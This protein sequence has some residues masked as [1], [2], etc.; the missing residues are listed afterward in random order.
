MDEDEIWC[1]TVGAAWP[2][3]KWMRRSLA[4]NVACWRRSY[5]GGIHNDSTIREPCSC[6]HCK[7]TLEAGQSE[8]F[9]AAYAAGFWPKTARTYQLVCFKRYLL[10]VY[11]LKL[12]LLPRVL[13]R[14]KIMMAKKTSTEGHD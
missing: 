3:V 10:D 1:Q 7:K 6:T 5:I 2:V 13:S 9:G 4:P 14:D 8:C 12:A 11:R